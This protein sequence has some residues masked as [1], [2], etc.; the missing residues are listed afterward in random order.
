[1]LNSKKKLQKLRLSQL[2]HFSTYVCISE[3]VRLVD[4]CCLPGVPSAGDS[5]RQSGSGVPQTELHGQ[6]GTT[7]VQSMSL[8]PLY[9]MQRPPNRTT[10]REG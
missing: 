8:S 4:Q 10:E 5:Q 6:R 2:L 1:M 9:V 3:A 7:Q